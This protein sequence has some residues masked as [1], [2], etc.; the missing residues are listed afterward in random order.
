MN[1]PNDSLSSNHGHAPLP[2]RVYIGVFAAL[3]VLT[4]LTVYVASIN[5]G[6]WNTPVALG[7]AT[8][9]GSLVALFFMHLWYDNKAN[10]LVLIA[11]IFFVL[12]L[13]FPIFLDVGTRAASG[14]LL[15]RP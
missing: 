7:I 12:V 9:K 15:I 6:A 5:F 11:A 8:F 3:L 2:L 10:L 14:P 1:T 13:F 4:F